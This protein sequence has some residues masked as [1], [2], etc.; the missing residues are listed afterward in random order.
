MTAPR[1]ASEDGRTGQ[2]RLAPVAVPLGCG[3]LAAFGATPGPGIL[4]GA[5]FAPVVMLPFGL[6]LLVGM[7]FA[8]VA[9]LRAATGRRRIGLGI[10]LTLL[11]PVGIG[12]ELVAQGEFPLAPLHGIPVP[13]VIGAVVAGISTFAL[14]GWSKLVGGLTIVLVAA[15]YASGTAQDAAVR[16]SGAAA[17]EASYGHLRPGA[18]TTASGAETDQHLATC[19]PVALPPLASPPG[20]C[21]AGE[22]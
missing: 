20:P 5:M 17:R 14:P 9:L 13:V 19:P 8:N 18:T 6:L 12:A 2:D 7:G 15:L 21:Q 4:V 22:P 3:A 16:A 11:V 1:P 10:V